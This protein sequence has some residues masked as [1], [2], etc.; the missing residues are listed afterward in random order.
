MRDLSGWSAILLSLTI[1]ISACGKQEATHEASMAAA[2]AAGQEGDPVK[3]GEYLVNA[4]GCHDCHTPFAMAEHGPEPDMTR[5]LWGHPQELVMPE[6]ELPTPPWVWVGSG[7]NTAFRGPWGV[8]YAA[9]LTSSP[10]GVGNW[11]EEMFVNT[12]RQGKRF[13]TGRPL[14]PP[15]P[16][17]A[18]RN[19]N[20]EDLKAIFAY[21]KTTTPSD[22]RPP[23]W[24]PPQ[25][26]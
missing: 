22:N 8:S 14:M 15:M 21:L 17:P 11:T 13:G 5:A 12:I 9:N 18:Y 16:W 25:Q 4:L 7:T 10:N 1:L 24:Q 6:I 26:Q 3:H 2:P 20:D 23:D 19:L